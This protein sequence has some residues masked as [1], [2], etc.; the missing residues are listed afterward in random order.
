MSLY[1]RG[2]W[3]QREDHLLLSLIFTQGRKNW[4]T[5]SAAMA[6]RSPKQCR[7][8]YQQHLRPGLKHGPITPEEGRIING[9][10]ESIGKQWA[11]IA[12]HLQGRS[13][14]AI[15]NWWYSATNRR[16][17]DRPH[18]LQSY[19]TG[20]TQPL[21]QYPPVPSPAS[22]CG[23]GR[24]LNHSDHHPM[25]QWQPA[26][27]INDVSHYR[28]PTQ[29]YQAT[30]TAPS[31]VSCGHA[32]MPGHHLA[33]PYGPHGH[34]TFHP[35][36]SNQCEDRDIQVP[37]WTS[38]KESPTMIPGPLY[39]RLNT[40]YTD[41]PRQRVMATLPSQA[42]SLAHTIAN[43]RETEYADRYSGV[44]IDKE[45]LQTTRKSFP[46]MSH[47]VAQSSLQ[48]YLFHPITRSTEGHY[49]LET[50]VL[51]SDHRQEVAL[52]GTLSPMRHRMSLSK[53]ISK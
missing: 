6:T 42:T 53:V 37:R 45:Q 30:C 24:P 33:A 22:Y 26:H 14:N 8:R 10:V 34:H 32:A 28:V 1:K 4:V 19:T 52:Q 23:K 49:Y 36:M 16:Q 31:I 12:R 48:D 18:D 25:L 27:M 47:S 35:R 5:I 11:R 3:L 7:E 29:S 43:G 46:I 51:K 41:V 21:V 44:N 9:M 17:H 50:E 38:S 2:Q 15:K 39:S 13:D 20:Y 40:S